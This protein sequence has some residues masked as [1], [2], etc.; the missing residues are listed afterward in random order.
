[1]L[2]FLRRIRVSGRKARVRI[3]APSARLVLERLED[4]VVPVAPLPPTG[5]KV[6]G[7]ST[8]ALALTW[9]PSQDPTVTGYNVTE[10][11]W[12]S[13]LHGGGSWHYNPIASNLTTTSDTVN[14][15]ATGSH[16]IYVV[17]AVN[18][19][20]KSFYSLPATGQTWSAPILLDGGNYV[21]LSN[22]TLSTGPVNA[23]AGLTTQV[24]IL[25]AGNPLTFSVVSGPSTVS[26]KATT[27]VVTYTP[28]ASEVGTV[29][30]TLEASNSLGSVR[31]TIQFTVAA[32]PGR[33]RPKLALTATSTTFNFQ[34]Q[35]ATA[36]AL[37]TDGVTPVN[38]TF[39]FA[40]NGYPG[41]VYNAGN[42]QLLVTFT[43]SDPTYGNATLLTTFTVFQ[44][45][46][47]FSYLQSKTFAV[48][49][50]PLLASGYIGIGYTGP[51]IHTPAGE[52]V[53]ITLNG[54]SQ[55]AP[56]QSNGFF[57]TTFATGSLAV[58]S[59]TMTYI[60]PGDGG[61]FRNA[62]RGI[63]TLD[64]IPQAPPVVTVNP[65]N[66]TTTAGDPVSF[67]AT[68]T[69]SNPPTVV[70]QVSLDGGLTWIAATGTVTTT[71][72]ATSTTTTLTF[73]TLAGENGYEFRA[74]FTNELG[75]LATSAATLTVE[76]DT[77]G[78]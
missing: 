68:A 71:S 21:Q 59:Y 47:T 15:L 46:P 73:S 36:T 70:W 22:G 64:V 52:Y 26:I 51:N 42:Y 18:A 23:T 6:V 49:T 66:A 32:N 48:G 54:V 33:P 78:P 19:S 25:A 44:A 43:S 1:M 60:Y 16:H 45:A 14:G 27:G 31:Q 12:V 77:G 28:A 37:G 7:F 40:Y 76:P 8:S 57:S 34:D 72:T 24:V 56:I 29:H 39:T 58:G 9:N 35:Q 5:L 41:P 74:L 30:V 13:Y 11:Y 38:G 75:S 62:P 10:K 50:T 61:E 53:I 4:R 20:G 3:G 67:R 69:G 63:T 65:T 2:H 17:T 55:A